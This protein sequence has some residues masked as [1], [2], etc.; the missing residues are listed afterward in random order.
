MLYHQPDYY[1]DT[2]VGSLETTTSD[3]GERLL[4]RAYLTNYCRTVSQAGLK[5]ILPE[6]RHFDICPARQL[7]NTY[8]SLCYFRLTSLNTASDHVVR[9]VACAQVDP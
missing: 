7:S 1:K 6:D 3:P 8:L 9:D 5:L 2:S 4:E